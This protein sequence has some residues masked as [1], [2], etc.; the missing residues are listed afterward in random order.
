ML[1]NIVTAAMILAAAGTSVAAATNSNFFALHS[2]ATSAKSIDLGTVVASGDGTIEVYT[3]HAGV[4]G[5]LLGT[6]DVHYGT[7]QNVS[8]SLDMAPTTDVIAVLKVG[9]SVVATSE[10]DIEM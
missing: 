5:D 2:A 8:V 9:G 7:N 10:Y 1:K 6:A 4:Q 3:Y